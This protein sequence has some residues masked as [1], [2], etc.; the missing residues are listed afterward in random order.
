MPRKYTLGRRE[1]A[2]SETRARI[3]SA[4]R[5]LLMSRDGFLN[6]T[7]DGI[8]REAGVSRVTVYNQFESKTAIYEALADELALHGKIRDRLAAAFMEPDARKGL[9]KLIDAF[10][11]FWLS[12]P[13]VLNK[14][15]AMSQLDPDS[16]AAERDAWRKEAIR[17]MVERLH[18]QLKVR[19]A[20]RLQ[21]DI[22]AIFMLTGFTTCESLAREGRSERQISNRIRELA[23]ACLEI[24]LG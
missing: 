4:A 7:V 21:R 14:L 13:D 23:G 19:G 16:K 2:V 22:D 8:A 24:S 18:K 11:H 15:H 5:D 12:E 20:A 17:T 9:S 6:F 10:V 1:Q 3:V